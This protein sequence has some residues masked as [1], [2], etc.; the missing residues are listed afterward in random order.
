MTPSDILI[1]LP[2]WLDAAIA[3]IWVSMALLHGI[4]IGRV[5]GSP[6]RWLR[7][8]GWSILCVTWGYRLVV[9]GNV[10]ISVPSVVAV[11]LLA[12]ASVIG[13]KHALQEW[14][15]DIRCFKDNHLKCH[16]AD[17][18]QQELRRRYR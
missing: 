13:A 12:A 11:L 6:E 15:A 3:L 8:V 7:L 5:G 4:L 2:G 10:T 9:F 16:R 14:S 18:V 17:R 1:D